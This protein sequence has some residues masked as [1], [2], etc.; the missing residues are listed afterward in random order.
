MRSEGEESAENRGG[1][2]REMKERIGVG[3]LEADQTLQQGC[4]PKP[5][6]NFK[7]VITFFR[8]KGG[9]K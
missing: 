2:G 1:R 8:D 4:R 7:S 9:H 6:S 5:F 3:Y